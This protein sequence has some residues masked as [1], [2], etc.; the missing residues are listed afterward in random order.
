MR[1]LII[2]FA[3]AITMWGESGASA[4]SIAASYCNSYS[5]VMGNALMLQ[6]QGVP[7]D[8][9]LKTV[10]SLWRSNPRLAGFMANSIEMAY[11]NPGAIQQVL[12]DGRWQS[13]CENYL[14]GR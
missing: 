5:A 1:V 11:K 4:Q 12:Q 10:S 3:I 6:K 7:L 2:I 8:Y 9:A 13:A 14:M